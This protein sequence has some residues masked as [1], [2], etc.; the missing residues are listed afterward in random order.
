ML[1]G[2]S[3]PNVLDAEREAVRSGL[4]SADLDLEGLEP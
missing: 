2:P 3:L 1:R 4:S